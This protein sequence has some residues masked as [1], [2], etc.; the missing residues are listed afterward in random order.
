M[1]FDLSCPLAVQRTDKAEGMTWSA[2]D[3]GEL[4]LYLL[5]RRAASP[6]CLPMYDHSEKGV[7]MIVCG[8][9]RP[10]ARFGD[11]LFY[12]RSVTRHPGMDCS[13]PSSAVSPAGSQ[14][15]EYTNSSG[16]ACSSV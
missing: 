5:I 10:D 12:H 1:I 15:L 3:L 11:S 9:M 8:V 2:G 16:C 6:S 4:A 7:K 13:E 14:P